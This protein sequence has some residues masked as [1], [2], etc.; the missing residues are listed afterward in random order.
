ML[1]S[2]MDVANG[3]LVAVKEVDCRHLSSESELNAVKVRLRHFLMPRIHEE[4][5][6]P[7]IQ[8]SVYW[9]TTYYCN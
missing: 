4:R 7:I 5:G 9:C 3:K 8:Y 1:S 2:G 6:W